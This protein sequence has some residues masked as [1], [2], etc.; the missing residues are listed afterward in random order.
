MLQQ[1]LMFDNVKHPTKTHPFVDAFSSKSSVIERHRSN[2]DQENFINCKTLLELTIA[3]I[4]TEQSTV[5]PN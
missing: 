3:E 5:K 4:V 1:L 2:V